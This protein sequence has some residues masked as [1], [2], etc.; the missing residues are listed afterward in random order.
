M[1]MGIRG[2][3][4]W[5]GDLVLFFILTL[6]LNLVVQL[7]CFTLEYGWHYHV[8]L[9]TLSYTIGGYFISCHRRSGWYLVTST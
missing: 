2:G 4:I 3:R 1:E 5:S 9:S 8:W 7:I 6:A